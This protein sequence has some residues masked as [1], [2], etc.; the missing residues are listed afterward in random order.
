MIARDGAASHRALPVPYCPTQAGALI[1]GSGV[2]R[3]ATTWMPCA[4]SRVQ[5]A[6]SPAPSAARAKARA[7]RVSPR[8]VT[9]DAAAPDLPPASFDV[10]LARHVLWAMPDVDA[11]LG[12]WIRLLRPD[13]TLLLAEGR[14]H[15]GVGLSGATARA[16]VLRHRAEAVVTPL[17]DPDLWGGPIRDE[18]YLLVSAR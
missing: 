8:F 12:E 6:A 18:R 10:V 9:S 13:G 5:Y 11:A 14:W 15:T 16:A 3:I 2:S 1:P 7:A 4:R 17:D